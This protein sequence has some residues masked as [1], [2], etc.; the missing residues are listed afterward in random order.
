MNKSAILYRMVTDNHIC[1]FG[2]RSKDLLERKGYDID[3]R[4]S[5]LGKKPTRS[6]Q[7]TMLKQPHRR[8]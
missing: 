4:H 7:S 6:R 1:P 8:L 5:L 3:D 2:L